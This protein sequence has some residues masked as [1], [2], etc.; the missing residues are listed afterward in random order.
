MSI[1]DLFPSESRASSRQIL[2]WQRWFFLMSPALLAILIMLPRLLSPQFGLFDDG[3]T[4]RTVKEMASGNWQLWDI[5]LGRFRP[6]YW[7]WWFLLYRIFGDNP[8][9]FF[10]GNTILLALSALMIA[11]IIRRLGGSTRQ[12]WI[13][14]MLFVLSGPIIENYYTLSKG[15]PLQVFW[16][17][18]S[19]LLA[20]HYE[21]TKRIAAQVGLV[22]GI[23][24]F[25]W[26]SQT[27]KETSLVI[28]PIA[29]GWLLAG[30]IQKRWMRKDMYSGGRVAY[31]TGAF[32]GTASFFS[33]RAF[34]SRES[35]TAIGYATNYELSVANI[36][37]SIVRWT[38]WIFRDYFYIAPLVI[39]IVIWL[40]SKRQLALIPHWLDTLIWMGGWVAIYLP[41]AST[42]GYFLLPFAIGAS[43]LAGVAIDVAIESIPA[44]SRSIRTA[45]AFLLAS[46][47]LLTMIHLMNNSTSARIQMAVDAQN[48]RVIKYLAESIP[49]DSLVLVNIQDPNEYVTELE[50]H[51]SEIQTR[52][53]VAIDVIDPE[54]LYDSIDGHAVYLLIPSIENQLLLSIRMGIYEPTLRKWNESIEDYLKAHGRLIYQDQTRFKLLNF[55]LP[56]LLCPFYSG[57]NFCAIGQPL[58]DRRVFSYGWSVYEVGMPAD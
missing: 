24:L 4:L 29:F 3:I 6:I 34:F 45:T 20:T 25:V 31:F 1:S 32:I 50:L 21:R 44:S 48:A 46:A 26:C 28:L 40:I 5:Q 14:S 19:L 37:A 13:T 53:D 38:G 43:M 23:A 36:I 35:L 58:I 49:E 57:R 18:I 47:L 17:L 33:S 15:E 8:L 27:S 16:I 2:R 11:L 7:L 52:S 9:G 12:G 55:D 39:M 51:I 10:L 22:L 41:W 30:W 54:D 42:V 56:R